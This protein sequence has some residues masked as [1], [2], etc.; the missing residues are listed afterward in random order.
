MTKPTERIRRA[1]RNAFGRRRGGAGAVAAA[2]AVCAVL[3][4]VSVSAV[5]QNSIA[6][7]PDGEIPENWDDPIPIPWEKPHIQEPIVKYHGATPSRL[8]C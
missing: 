7:Q 5:G 4:C 1:I 8:P 6:C 3:V 2:L